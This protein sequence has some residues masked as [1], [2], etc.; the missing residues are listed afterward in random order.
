MR[1]NFQRQ[2]LVFTSKFFG[3]NMLKNGPKHG[4]GKQNQ[5]PCHVNLITMDWKVTVH[6]SVIE[7]NELKDETEQEMGWY[8]KE[9]YKLPL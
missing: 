1:R 5:V 2:V 6:A 7:G 8:L 3:M 4:D 9:L